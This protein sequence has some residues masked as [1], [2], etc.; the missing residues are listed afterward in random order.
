MANRELNKNS[1]SRLIRTP[2]ESER[3][4]TDRSLESVNRHLGTSP[5]DK[6]NNSKLGKTLD[7]VDLALDVGTMVLPPQI[8]MY[9]GKAGIV[10]G[11]PQAMIG[12]KDYLWNVSRNG[13][14][15][16]TLDQVAAMSKLIP[17]SQMFKYFGKTGSKLLGKSDKYMRRAHPYIS[18]EKI[19]SQFRLVL[20]NAKRL[21]YFVGTSVIPDAINLASDLYEL[22]V[23]D[24][25]KKNLEFKPTKQQST[26][27]T[28]KYKLE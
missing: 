19:P 1:K 10:T 4:K 8:G 2:E 20:D 25:I 3:Y 28:S 9:A 17:T 16:P 18:Y 15:V 14:S 5:L 21:P 12:A 13:I 6:F 26:L 23:F 22:G 27:N 7:A 11:I 24:D